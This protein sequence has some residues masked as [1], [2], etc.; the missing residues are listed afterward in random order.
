[1]KKLLSILIALML[2]LSSVSTSVYAK[3]DH[4]N[5]KSK[6]SY[7]QEMKKLKDELKKWKKDNKKREEILKKIIELKVDFD[8]DSLSVFVNGDDID[9]SRSPVIKYGQYKL[10][11][12]PI[13]KGLDA[14]LSY[15]NR[16]KVIK[17]TK[18]DTVITID[19]L[20]KKVLKNDVEIKTDLFNNKN[21]NKTIVLVKF[22]A[23]I[24]GYRVD[25]DDDSGTIIIDDESYITINDSDPQFSYKGTW[26]YTQNFTG[27]YNNDIHKSNAKYS[28]Y[29]IN[30]NGTGIKI[31]GTTGPDHGVAS[32]Y[33]DGKK[34]EANLYSSILKNNVIIF[35]S[36]QL[37]DGPHKLEV[38]VSGKRDRRSNGTYIS[39][40]KVEVIGK[41]EPI[42]QTDVALNKFAFSDSQEVNNPAASGNDGKLDTRWSANN[43]ATGHWWMVDL[44]SL[45]TL[46]GSQ[47]TWEFPNRVYKY[48]IETSANGSDWSVI[49]DKTNNASNKQI[50]AESF[51]TNSVQ[52]VRV[53]VTGLETG[54]WASFWDIKLFGKPIATADT[55]APSI[56][57]GLKAKSVSINQIDLS[58][59]ASTDNV[60]VAGY[61]V[62]RNGV[63]I[64]TVASNSLKYSDKGLNAGTVYEYSIKAYD[65][66]NNESA[67]SSSV[68]AATLGIGV[69]LLAEYYDDVALTP[70]F[71]KLARVDPTINFN[72]NYT[73]PDSLIDNDTF[74]IRWSGQLQAL[75]SEKYTIHAISDDGIRVWVNNKLIIDYWSDHE[76]IEKTGTIDLI[77]GQKYSIKVEYYENS[78][79]ASANLL[80]SSASQT[81]EVIPKSQLYLQ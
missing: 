44:G 25:S 17:I 22:I 21:K 60:A 69:G 2:I 40:D 41:S 74:S 59:T 68:K 51:N 46:T 56:P 33:V 45:Y 71:L 77:A 4:S 54:A 11:T 19:L 47:I 8:D 73:S 15:S 20:N 37:N 1:M 58:W 35:T 32:I 65:A 6:K 52:Y 49:L 67:A 53:I 42:T 63:Q 29:S 30:F 9:L 31:Y 64:A 43:S 39:V 62:L 38:K 57:T 80:W 76:A 13:T 36:P 66:K 70:G 50:Q 27:A 78:G 72:W 23:N 24:L 14:K 48:K 7:T 61:K 81:K 79:L 55:Q 18:N 26:T 28:S 34:V 12:R 3:N 10:P 16:K 75:Y 5:S